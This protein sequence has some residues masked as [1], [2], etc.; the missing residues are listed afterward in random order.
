MIKKI[1]PTLQE[2][3]KL[4]LTEAQRSSEYKEFSKKM[5]V[6]QDAE[7]PEKKE[8]EKQAFSGYAFNSQ[9]NLTI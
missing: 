4:F 6:S 2:A 5:G 8:T 3:I 7:T 1:F 9:S